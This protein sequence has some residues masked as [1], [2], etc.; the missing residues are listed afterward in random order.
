V[1]KR[2]YYGFDRAGFEVTWLLS[3]SK[4]IGH[5]DLFALARLWETWKN[6]ALGGLGH[7]RLHSR[8]CLLHA[9]AI[10]RNVHTRTN[11][12][13]TDIRASLRS[14]SVRNLNHQFPE[15]LSAQQPHECIRRVLQSAHDILSILDLPRLEL[16][17][18]LL[19]EFAKLRSIILEDNESLHTDI[20]DLVRTLEAARMALA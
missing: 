1:R 3:N 7:H 20:R 2:S 15:V 19:S 18:H 9:I 10:R 11:L 12:A 8:D 5:G 16:F 17:R 4:S 13:A 14:S 6:G